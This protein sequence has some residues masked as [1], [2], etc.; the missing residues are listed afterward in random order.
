MSE[1]KTSFEHYFKDVRHLEFI[2]VYRVGL[3]WNVTDPALFH[4]LKK[5]LVAGDRGVKDQ[6]TDI[7]EAITTLKRWLAIQQ[8][9][10]RIIPHT[11]ISK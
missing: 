11:E 2:D 6:E 5:I 1:I 3:L 7:E 10:K 4:A 9:D 8:E